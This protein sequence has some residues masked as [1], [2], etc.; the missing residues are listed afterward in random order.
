MQKTLFLICFISCFIT[1]LSAQLSRIQLD[2]IRADSLMK[3]IEFEHFVANLRPKINQL[4]DEESKI[5]S[6]IPQIDHRGLWL[7]FSYGSSNVRYQ[8]PW[9]IDS[10]CGCDG[11]I[12]LDTSWS[13]KTKT[14]SMGFQATYRFSQYW[15][16]RTNGKILSLNVKEGSRVKGLNGEFAELNMDYKFQQYAANL[17]IVYYAGNKKGKFR[18]RYIHPYFGAGIWAEHTTIDSSPEL[19][20]ASNIS[21]TANQINSKMGETKLQPTFQPLGFLG[22]RAGLYVQVSYEWGWNQKFY[23]EVSIDIP[24]NRSL[25]KSVRK[26]RTQQRVLEHNVNCEQAAYINEIQGKEKQLFPERFIVK[27]IVPKNEDN[28]SSGGGSGVSNSCNSNSNSKN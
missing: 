14:Q 18:H 12:H 4:K 24:L 15:A 9:K 8:E 20:Q 27:P 5:W 13:K 26:H 28:D 22:V 16:L 10:S 3:V 1:S 21:E 11:I 23:N 6:S 25:Y 2:S 7:G 17:S 19:R